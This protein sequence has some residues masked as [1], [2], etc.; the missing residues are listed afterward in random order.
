M[1]YSDERE[2]LTSRV[3]RENRFF[4]QDGNRVIDLVIAYKGRGAKK[5]SKRTT[6]RERY[7]E[8]LKTDRLQFE[9][10]VSRIFRLLSF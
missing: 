1:D 7:I 9:H 6:S 8:R 2:V 3:I 5:H 10:V 4:F